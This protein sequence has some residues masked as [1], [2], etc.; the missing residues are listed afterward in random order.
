MRKWSALIVAFSAAA[1][2]LIGTAP[3]RDAGPA[4]ERAIDMADIRPST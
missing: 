2:L 4:E 3:A 1:A